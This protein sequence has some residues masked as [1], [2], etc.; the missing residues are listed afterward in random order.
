[1]SP[2]VA[3]WRATDRGSQAAFEQYV[4]PGEDAMK[5]RVIYTVKGIPPT[6]IATPA[7]TF[8][9]VVGVSLKFEEVEALNATAEGLDELND[10]TVALTEPPAN[11]TVTWYARDV[12][13]VQSGSEGSIADSV[14]E[15]TTSTGTDTPP[16]T[17]LEGCTDLASSEPTTQAFEPTS[18]ED[19]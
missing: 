4:E 18:P 16:P 8:T 7:G 5:L 1:M 10:T 6:E 13:T 11:S 3:T 9:D 2:V 14:V 17:Q 15:A 12:G 19:S